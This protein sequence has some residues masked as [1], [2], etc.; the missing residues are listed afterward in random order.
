MSIA[1]ASKHSPGD[2]PRATA[3]GQPD[4]RPKLD[5]FDRS[6]LNFVIQWR[7]YGLPPD[8]ESL[9]L[10]GIRERDLPQRIHTIASAWLHRDISLM[11]RVQI[12]RALAAVQ[13]AL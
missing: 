8:E 9:P 2:L 5:N 4:R 11:D 1:Q 3:A 6:L 13:S 10:F 12:V 7:P